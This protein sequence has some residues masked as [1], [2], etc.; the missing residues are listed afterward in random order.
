M[1]VYG[2]DSCAYTRQTLASLRDNEIPVTYINID[3]AD[4]NKDFH[5]KFGKT[6]LDGGR[7]YALPVVDLAGQYSMRPNPDGVARQFR[8]MH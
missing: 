1:L 5:E 7:G 4:A 3:Y 2:R 8:S 6:G